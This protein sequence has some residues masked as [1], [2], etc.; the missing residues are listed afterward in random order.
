MS[1][2][3][4][5]GNITGME[6]FSYTACISDRIGALNL[7]IVAEGDVGVRVL[8]GSNGTFYP[9]SDKV[10]GVTEI[11]NTLVNVIR[12]SRIYINTVLPNEVSFT[13]AKKIRD[14]VER[15][16]NLST[17]LS[18]R[19][20][21]IDFNYG[22]A[23]VTIK[24]IDARQL[25]WVSMK[26]D[27]CVL[28]GFVITDKIENAWKGMDADI[29]RICNSIIKLSNIDLNISVNNQS[30]AMVVSMLKSRD[31]FVITDN[32]VKYSICYLNESEPVIVSANVDGTFKVRSSDFYKDMDLADDEF[33]VPLLGILNNQV[34]NTKF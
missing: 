27:T 13:I 15:N 7:S 33:M 4:R 11:G 8:I 34:I 16:I 1:A 2:L 26:V 12:D 22:N 5:L 3:S 28:C 17:K 20:Y 31:G 6:V 19:W 32:Y 25:L 29:N 14:Y 21:S 30:W 18:G 23:V 24:W 9:Y 10:D